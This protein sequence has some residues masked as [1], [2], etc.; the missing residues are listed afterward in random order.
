M[1]Q[2][3]SGGKSSA[4]VTELPMNIKHIIA[5]SWE[6]LSLVQTNATSHLAQGKEI[7]KA[8]GEAMEHWMIG[9][10]KQIAGYQSCTTSPQSLENML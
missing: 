1:F 4:P 5:E 10:E 9:Q 7:V 3:D 6:C 8:L 2:A